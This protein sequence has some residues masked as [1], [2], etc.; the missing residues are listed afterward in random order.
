MNY[1]IA[2]VFPGMDVMLPVHLYV[3]KDTAAIEDNT[4]ATVVISTVI[5]DFF[6]QKTI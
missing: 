1:R 2:Y 5:I 6:L 3:K 4:K